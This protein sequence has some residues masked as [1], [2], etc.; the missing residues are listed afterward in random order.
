M[1]NQKLIVLFLLLLFLIGGFCGCTEQSGIKTEEVISENS[2]EKNNNQKSQDS[3]I[4]YDFPS[5]LEIEYFWNDYFTEPRN[6]IT[7]YANG[8]AILETISGTSK[9]QRM[10]NFTKEELFDIYVE[11]LNNNFFKLNETYARDI[12]ILD[13]SCSSLKVK[14]DKVEYKVSIFN[15][16]VEEIENISQ[17]IISI[18]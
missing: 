1:I 17:K 7:I 6:T 12:M 14:A 2:G 8:T 13:G 3:I 9:E 15:Y 18:L 10:Y 5:N 11:I 4:Q 16:K